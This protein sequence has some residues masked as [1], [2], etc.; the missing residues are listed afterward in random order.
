MVPPMEYQDE[1]LESKVQLFQ[2]RDDMHNVSDGMQDD[3]IRKRR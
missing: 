1:Q 3:G 2:E